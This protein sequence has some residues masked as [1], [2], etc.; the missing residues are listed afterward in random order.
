VIPLAMV[1]RVEIEKDGASALYGADAIGGVVNII[2]RPVFDG[3]DASLLTS[4]ST[5]GDG[6]EYDGSFVTGFSTRDR[7]SYLVASVGYQRHEPVFA[8]DRAFSRFQDSYDFTRK[9]ASHT[10]S[11]AAPVGRVAIGSLGP[12]GA[13]PDGCTTDACKPVSDGQWT[14]F[15]S[16]DLYDDAAHNYLYTPSSRYN[17]FATAGNQLGD[18]ARVVLELLYLSRDSS[19]ELSPVA[20]DALAPISKDSLYNPLGADINDFRR[21]LT[22]LGPRHYVDT[23]RTTRLLF[24]IAGETPAAAPVLPGWRYEVSFNYGTTDAHL[25]TTGQLVLTHV[26]DSLGPSMLDATGTPI[27]VRVPGD[28]STKITYKVFTADPLNDDPPPAREIPCVPVNLL[29]PA[30]KIPL[31]QLRTLTFSDAGY[32]TD[33]QHNLLATA[34]GR[35]WALPDHGEVALALGASHRTESGLTEPPS[36]ASAGYGYTTDDG[37]QSTRGD[38]QISEGFAELSVVPIVDRPFVRRLELDLGGRVLRQEA[39]GQVATYQVGAQHTT[40]ATYKLGALARTAV[41]V[42][43]RGTFATA[44]RAPSIRDLVGGH[45]ERTVAVEDPCDTRPPSAGDAPRTLEPTVQAMCTA[46]GVPAGLQLTTNQTQAFSGGNPALAPETAS[47]ATIG[48][49]VE[50][51]RAPGLAITLDYWRVRIRQAIESLGVPIILANCYERGIASFCDQIFRDRATH[52]LVSVDQRL[53]NI[54]QTR[55]SG[56]DLALRYD[57]ELG[58]IG[59]VRTALE[60]QY[61][62][63]YDLDTASQTVHGVGYYDLGVYPRVKANLS[64]H[65]QHPSGASAGATLRYIGGFQE[66]AGNNCNSADHRANA[67]REVD[68][69]VKLD[70]YAGYDLRDRIGKTSFQLGINNALDASPPTIYNAPAANSDAQTYDFL[71]RMIFVRMDHQF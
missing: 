29:A 14:N 45:L 1:E 47:T 32:G 53:Q 22:E 69:Y 24:G 26:R 41:G 34:R 46:Q 71:G 13:R 65:W 10:D 15:T 3:A 2:T 31:D 54:G 33:S 55:T 37:E 40:T 49:V 67:S 68:R 38:L 60:A 12:G 59:R 70:L 39:A 27:C 43:A 61:L 18:H 4:S 64:G 58:G 8:G 35:L 57:G 9:V 19:R 16:D 36:A 7:R 42:A 28:A 51:P 63:A 56:L 21:R 17:L 48:V 50:P 6:L 20:F 5:R 30:G 44:F 66:C 25:G 52:R 62:L 23:V 11:L